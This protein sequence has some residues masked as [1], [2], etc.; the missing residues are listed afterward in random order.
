MTVDEI[1]ENVIRICREYHVREAY[2][3]G[4]RAKG[5]ATA[6]S[7]F[8]IAVTGA[9]DFEALDEAIDEIPTL[10]SFDVVNMDTCKND[11]LLEEIKEYG[12][13]IL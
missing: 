3:F 1:M 10:F 4:S 7:D 12:R 2:L 9:S 13:K 5:T 8:D 11:L 6:R